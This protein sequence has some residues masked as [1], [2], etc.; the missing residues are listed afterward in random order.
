MVLD[1]SVMESEA[2]PTSNSSVSEDEEPEESFLEDYFSMIQLNDG[3]YLPCLHFELRDIM[4]VLLEKYGFSEIRSAL[5]DCH[6]AT[7]HN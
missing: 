5:Y 7:Q 3:T 1:D 2:L 4:K 6:S